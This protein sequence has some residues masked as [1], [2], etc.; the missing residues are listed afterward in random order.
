M[1]VVVQNSRELRGYGSG[2]RRIALHK[3]FQPLLKKFTKLQRLLLQ[4]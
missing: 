3:K 2:E 1:C 4:K